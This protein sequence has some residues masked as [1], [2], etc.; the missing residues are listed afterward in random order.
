MRGASTRRYYIYWL[1]SKGL[2]Y[3]EYIDDQGQ[4][5]AEEEDGHNTEQH[6]G[7]ALFSGLAPDKPVYY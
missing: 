3:L 2:T 6:P 5:V 4:E 7:E 1:S